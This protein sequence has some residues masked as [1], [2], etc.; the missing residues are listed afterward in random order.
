ML[1]RDSTATN[2]LVITL[3]YRKYHI[4]ATHKDSR[5]T[6]KKIDQEKTSSV[7]PPWLLLLN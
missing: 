4:L 6:I 7:I 2:I 1:Y 5:W 3:K